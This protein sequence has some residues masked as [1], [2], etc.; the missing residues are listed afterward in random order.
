M[1]FT[2]KPH[3]KKLCVI[4]IKTFAKP[5][6]FKRIPAVLEVHRILDKSTQIAQQ[7]LTEIES[8]DDP[9]WAESS[10][11]EHVLLHIDLK[12]KFPKLRRPNCEEPFITLPAFPLLV[13]MPNT[14]NDQE[15]DKTNTSTATTTIFEKLFWEYLSNPSHKFMRENNDIPRNLTYEQVI[16]KNYP[17]QIKEADTQLNRL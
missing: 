13:P 17:A 6:D 16:K 10:Y 9:K 5:L 4:R 3:H 12:V 7:L 14:Q 1:Q 15:S 11:C 8:I 2:L